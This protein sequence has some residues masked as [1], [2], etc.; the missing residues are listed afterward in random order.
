MFNVI[1]PCRFYRKVIILVSTYLESVER[2]VQSESL[3]KLFDLLVEH[4]D[5]LSE[6]QLSEFMKVILEKLIY[7]IN[8]PEMLDSKKYIRILF[9]VE[10]M[11]IYADD[12]TMGVLPTDVRLH[13]ISMMI[14]NMNE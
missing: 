2:T 12:I 10:Y 7:F 6:H 5:K 3:T 1:V 11:V 4:R 8:D 13:I 14:E 9:P